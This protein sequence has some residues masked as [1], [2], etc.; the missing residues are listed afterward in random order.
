MPT[1]ISIYLHMQLGALCC[2]SPAVVADSSH[3]RGNTSGR[4]DNSSGS[5]G[6]NSSYLIDPLLLNAILANSSIWRYAGASSLSALL[7]EFHTVGHFLS[8]NLNHV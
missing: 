4:N 3:L 7:G 8:E 5:R 6:A 2:C 1:V